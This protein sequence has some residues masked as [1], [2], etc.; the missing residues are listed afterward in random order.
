MNNID[1]L[2]KLTVDDFFKQLSEVKDNDG[3]IFNVLSRFA[4]SLATMYNSSSEA[5]RYNGRQ[6]KVKDESAETPSK[7]LLEVEG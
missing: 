1:K 3:P 7:T 6:E 5:E 4:L 2:V